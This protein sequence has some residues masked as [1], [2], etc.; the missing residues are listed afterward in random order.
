MSIILLVLFPLPPFFF[1]LLSFLLFNQA[2]DSNMCSEQR[3]PLDSCKCVSAPK[4]FG[5][6]YLASTVLSN[7]YHKRCPMKRSVC[8]LGLASSH[9]GACCGDCC[10]LLCMIAKWR[11]PKT[12]KAKQKTQTL[13]AF[14]GNSNRTLAIENTKELPALRPP[15]QTPIVATVGFKNGRFERKVARKRFSH[16]PFAIATSC[17]RMFSSVMCESYFHAPVLVGELQD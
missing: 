4:H 17:P 14:N 8:V 10:G 3:L 6:Q 15:H 9:F 12:P 7:S 1:L 5:S 13:Q 11:H 16:L 2:V